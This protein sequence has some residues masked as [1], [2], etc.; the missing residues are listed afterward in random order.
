MDCIISCSVKIK[1]EIK[2][3]FVPCSFNAS[4][5]FFIFFSYVERE[6]MFFINPHGLIKS[7]ISS[8]VIIELRYF[9]FRKNNKENNVI[10][11]SVK[12]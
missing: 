2:N 6:I 7:F 11:T 10:I 9:P 3:L 8:E 1:R 4:N 12:K 5:N